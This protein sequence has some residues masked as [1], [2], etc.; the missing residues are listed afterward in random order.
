MGVEI[1]RKFL[2]K[3]DAWREGVVR[4]QTMRQ[5]YLVGSGRASVRVRAADESAWLNIKGGGLV[6]VRQE[7]EYP[8]S[9]ADAAQL[10][11]SFCEGALVEKTRHWVPYRGFEW[12]IDEFH[13]SNQGLVVAELELDSEAQEFPRPDWLGV[14]VTELPRYYNVSL[15][16]HP[17]SAWDETERNW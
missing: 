2:L 17:Y 8:I 3:S 11:E 6:A 13:A 12:E 14:E 9:A 5:G 15:V 16:K 7:F 1:E 10:L 4:R